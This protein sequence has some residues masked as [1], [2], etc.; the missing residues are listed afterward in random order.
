M[1]RDWTAR[2]SIAIVGALLV[3]IYL[4][5]LTV[6]GRLDLTD[7]NVYSLSDASVKLVEDLDDPVTFKAFFT[8]NLPAPYGSNR[9]FLKDKLDDYRAY[10]GGN[11]QYQF[12]DPGEDDDVVEEARRFRIPPVQIQVIEKDNVQLKNAYM[13]LAIEYGGEREVIP[14]V[15]DL[16]TLEYDIT[17]AIRRLTREELPTVGFLTG[18]G[19]PNIFQDMPTL[20]Q[21]LAR[22][23]EV[24]AVT[25][26][27]ETLDNMPDVLLV[28]APTDS[29]PGEHVRAVDRYVMDGGRLGLLL[30][31]V[32]ADIQAGQASALS[33]G[34][35]PLL[36]TYGVG[37]QTNLVTDLQSSAVTVQQQAG[38]FNIARQIE[39]PFFPIA[40]S[41]NPDNLTVS[42]L[43]EVLFYFVSSI[44]TTAAL[45][46]GVT[47]E[48]LVYSSTRSA[49]Q[50]GFFFI[51]PMLET[52]PSYEDGP[53]LLAAAYSGNFP[54][55]FD[56]SRESVSTRVAVVGDGDFV[57][58]SL[59]GRI[60]GNIE[61]G[62]NL[63]DWLVQE[64]DLLEIRA[65]KIEPRA[66]REVSE[67]VRPW[68]KYTNMLVPALVVVGFG[69]FRWRRRRGREFIVLGKDR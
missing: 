52:R 20:R 46:A 1:K 53:F 65:K 23:Y 39:Y 4:I 25:I 17:S 29:L 34:L 45:P 41:F 33:V 14:V 35:E 21:G 43:R 58:E 60:P 61:L 9:R 62:L 13:G 66:L 16:S 15:Q 38:L 59:L 57:N 3:V 8:E 42:R 30:N 40:T 7:D 69:L 32:S 49:T 64:S 63:V 31:A 51:Q 48:P 67:E 11:I 44:D 50:E 27:G 12:I 68:I 18:H 37:L 19:E 6:F 56:P 47:V 26:S 10:G 5:G 24:T 2:S 22:N 28:I 36:E 54:S 55:V